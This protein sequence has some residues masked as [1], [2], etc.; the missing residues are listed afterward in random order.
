MFTR[1]RAWRIAAAALAVAALSWCGLAQAGEEF[2][3]KGAAYVSWSHDEYTYAAADDSLDDL[4]GTKANWAT[5]LVTWYMDQLD[6]NTIAPWD[7][8]PDNRKTPSDASVVHAIQDLHARGLKVC[9]KP[10]VDVKTYEW[11]GYINPADDNAWFT[12]YSA[13]TVHYA[14]MAQANDVEM[15]CIG[16]ELKTMSGITYQTQWNTVIDNIE[17]AYTG[18]LTYAPHTVEAN[19][20]HKT[21]CF[22]SRM[23]YG[24]ASVYSPLTNLAN[25]TVEQLVAAWS[26]NRSGVNVLQGLRNWQ[27]S[28]GKPVIFLEIGYQSAD[29]TNKT[30]WWV[31]SPVLDY[32]EQADC[33]EA[34]FRVWMPE[35][36]WMKGLFFWGWSVS[37]PTPTHFTARDKPAMA[38]M[39]KWFQP[40]PSVTAVSPSSGRM[41]GGTAVTVTGT[42]FET[43][44]G[45]VSVKFGADSATGV[46]I[47]DEA[48]LT[49]ATPS[50]VAGP[51]DVVVTNPNTLAGTLAG[52]YT[53]TGYEC[54]IGPRSALG[55]EDLTAGDL[56]QARRFA[57]GLDS[58]A[59]GP[60][61]QR[62]DC[63]PRESLGDGEFQAA[64]LSQARRYV[65]GLDPLAG[66]GGPS[67][68]AGAR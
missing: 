14:Q 64:D 57:A 67:T 30:P 63:A 31:D 39:R 3:Y 13:F 65:A 20:E 49:C 43:N 59:P 17:A 1:A 22:W 27:V 55:D 68:P 24:G 11:R 50:G 35:S 21:V 10:H 44:G 40:K 8:P 56:V 62:A 38:V 29:T 5:L 18:P 58:P 47:V 33:Y 16:T 51:A 37:D 32:Q 42:N 2:V 52:G 45:T 6:S 7:E 34:A 12:S 28:L 26:F 41:G 23:D 36:S 19:D 9:L 61:F 48:H 25:P 46:A 4:A 54:D 66:A 53:Y 15:Y 60:E